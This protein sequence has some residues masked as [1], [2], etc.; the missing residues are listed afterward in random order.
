MQEFRFFVSGVPEPE[1]RARVIR[2]GRPMRDRSGD[3]WKTTIRRAA[4]DALG[5]DFAPRAPLFPLPAPI[6][7]GVLVYLPRPASHFRTGRN[8]HLLKN[9]APTFPT[10]KPD[11]DNV[12]KALKDALGS[13]DGLPP[14][15]WTDDAQVI[16][17]D[18]PAYKLYAEPGQPTGILV[19]ARV[20]KTAPAPW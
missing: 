20:M 19:L 4:L 5:L 16:G 14:I 3:P 2:R 11:L 1:K 8:A 13:F 6:T 7:L 12:V 9:S 10:P 15:L 18:P 17:Y